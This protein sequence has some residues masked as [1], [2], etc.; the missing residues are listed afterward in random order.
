VDAAVTTD[1]ES[2]PLLERIDEQTYQRIRTGT[3]EL[4]QRFTTP[5]GALDAPFPRTWWPRANHSDAAA[6]NSIAV[7]E[8]TGRTA[9]P[10]VNSGAVVAIS[11]RRR[12][13]RGPVERICVGLFEF[14]GRQLDVGERVF[15]SEWRPGRTGSSDTL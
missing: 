10:M 3:R 12:R 14:A 5:T 4:W 9:N 6:L 7:D 1:V 11:R 2:T 15:V 8:A 13:S